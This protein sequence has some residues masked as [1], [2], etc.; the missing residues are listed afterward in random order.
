MCFS[1]KVLLVLLIVCTTVLF[2]AC[3]QFNE[4]PNMGTTEDDSTMKD[5]NRTDAAGNG[6]IDKNQ[7]FFDTQQTN[8]PT[9]EKIIQITT[10]MPFNDV[11]SL[12]GKPHGYMHINASSALPIS[13]KFIW[14]DDQG[15]PYVISFSF[16][17]TDSKYYTMD[18]NEYSQHLI[19]DRVPMPI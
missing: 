15:I 2:C 4:T 3:S 9:K 19:V 5:D 13:S 8:R 6:L 10:G 11:V 12:I 17:Q 14:T 7:D 18:L 1:N 16:V